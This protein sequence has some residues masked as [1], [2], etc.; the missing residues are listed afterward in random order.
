MFL[1]MLTARHRET[2]ELIR[3]AESRELPAEIA[4]LAAAIRATQADESTMMTKWLT[5]WDES[6]AM[7]PDDDVHAAHG[8]KTSLSPGDLADLSSSSSADFSTRFLNLLIAQQHNE[9]ELARMAVAEGAHPEFRELAGR[10][11]QSRTAQI[12]AMLEMVAEQ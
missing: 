2:A 8:G 5:R 12:G 6:T 3:V 7:D 10:I 9:V 4:T 11:D 1:Q